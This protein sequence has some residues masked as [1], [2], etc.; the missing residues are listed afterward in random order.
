[1]NRNEFMAKLEKQLADISKEEREEALQY[2]RD[3]FE[4][5]GAEHEIDVIRELGSPQRVAATIKADLKCDTGA[6]S[7]E[8]TERGYQDVRFENKETPAKQ[9]AN[10]Y[11]YTNAESGQKSEQ[12]S[13]KTNRGLKILLIALIILIGAPIVIPIAFGVVLAAVGIVIA[14][15]AFFAGLVAGAVV[16]MFAGAMIVIVGIPILV[17]ALP[18][19]LLTVGSGLL[20]FVIG[21]IATVATVKLCIVMY[22]AIVR[23]LVNICRWPFYRRKAVG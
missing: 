17:V 14:V 11:G 22:P 21:L 6:E 19:G 2:Y 15:F 10:T 5:A 13:P 7:G 18:A 1:M 20:I 16:I 4:D 3:Y 12:E 9:E 23:I 8:Y